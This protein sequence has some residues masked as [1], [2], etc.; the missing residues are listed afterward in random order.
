[1]ARDKYNVQ[2]WKVSRHLSC[3]DTFRRYVL[4]LTPHKYDH[5]SKDWTT[6]YL[7]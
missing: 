6:A 2:I 1:M 4:Y 5:E 3:G 7:S